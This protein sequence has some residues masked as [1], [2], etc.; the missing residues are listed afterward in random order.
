MADHAPQIEYVEA[1]RVLLDALTALTPHI[2]ALVLVGAQA[3]YLRTSGRIKTYQPFTTDA[4]LVLDPGLLGP[5]PPLGRAMEQAGF[6]LTDEPGIWEAHLTRPGFDEEITVPVDLI[7]PKQLA[8]TAGRRSARLPGEHGKSSARKSPGLEGAV[9]DNSPIELA[10][11]EDDDPRRITVNVVGF[12]A[13]FVAKLHKLGDRLDTPDRLLAKD[14]GDVYRLFDAISPGDMAT[15][16]QTLLA[17]DR[18]AA[19][20]TKALDY[21]EQLFV[22]TASTGTR[23]AVDALRTVLPEETV[24][25]AVTAYVSVLRRALDVV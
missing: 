2:D 8:P 16:L 6:T 19:T 3:V 18:S 22:T 7:V 9:V 23:L 4:D 13:L 1:R 25:A 24:T 21:L 20:T 5:I 12:G 17:D 10:S 11:L 14:A 15:T